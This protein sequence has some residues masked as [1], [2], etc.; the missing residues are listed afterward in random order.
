VYCR[1]LF[2]EL[3]HLRR[4]HAANWPL[5]VQLSSLETSLASKA[6]RTDVLCTLGTLQAMLLSKMDRT[7]CEQLLA[8]KLDIRTF[9]SA[10]SSASALPFPPSTCSGNVPITTAPMDAW[11]VEHAHSSAAGQVATGAAQGLVGGYRDTTAGGMSWQLD[12]EQQQGASSDRAGVPAAGQHM[13][14][15]NNLLQDS[16]VTSD[17]LC[18]PAIPPS[19]PS[20]MVCHHV[21]SG[22][23]SSVCTYRK[24]AA[25]VPAQTRLQARSHKC[26]H[27]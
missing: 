16:H 3:L 6:E 7:E 14:A 22:G 20:P 13:V 10:Q 18:T 9:L 8:R 21:P 17:R 27:T 2:P 25:T 23:Q 26:N 1:A 5:H 12:R 15:R 19:L 4:E 24:I 11:Q